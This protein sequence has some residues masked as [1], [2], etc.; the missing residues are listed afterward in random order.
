MKNIEQRMRVKVIICWTLAL[1]F[2]ALVIGFQ[3]IYLEP[4]T[5][6]LLFTVLVFVIAF[7]IR[8]LYQE[9]KDTMLQEMGDVELSCLRS[10]IEQCLK[11]RGEKNK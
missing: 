11:A 6:D 8:G 1:V 3:V 10:Q 7:G 5:E 9:N 4:E 2:I